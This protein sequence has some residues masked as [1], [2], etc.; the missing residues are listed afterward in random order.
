M[1]V[2]LIKLITGETIICGIE[3]ETEGAYE[4]KKPMVLTSFNNPGGGVGVG[5]G[6]PVTG[7]NDSMEDMTINREWIIAEFGELYIQSTLLE[8]YKKKFL[9]P[10]AL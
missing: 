7:L 8:A 10:L 6:N 4:V 1:G 2:K 3:E 5:F 9:C